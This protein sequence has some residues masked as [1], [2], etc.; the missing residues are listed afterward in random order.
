MS[1]YALQNDLVHSWYSDAMKRY[2]KYEFDKT[3]YVE[4]TF[5]TQDLDAAQFFKVLEHLGM[6]MY[7]L[8]HLRSCPHAVW[9]PHWEIGN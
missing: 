9:C 2:C 6:G 8:H 1:F 7:W 4:F 5:P 3:V